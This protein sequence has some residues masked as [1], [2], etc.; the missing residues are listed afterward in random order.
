MGMLVDGVWQERGYDTSAGGRFQ[1]D[2]TRFHNWITPDGA[3]GPTGEGGFAAARGR[4]HLYVSLACPWA[5][6]SIIFRRLKKLEDVISLSIVDPVMR[7]VGWR[8]SDSPAAI[9]DFVNGKAWLSEIYLMTDP[10]FTGRVT[11]PVLWDKEKKTIVNNESS[12]II[13]MLNSAFDKFTNAHEDYYPQPLR[14]EIDRI[15][16]FVY[17][18]VNNGVYRAGFATTQAAYDEAFRH[19]FIALDEI[20]RHLATHRYLAG[21]RITE[22]DWRLFTTLVRFDAVYY[23]HFKC[24]LRRI[25][26]YANL[27]NYLRELYQWPGVKDTVSFDHIKTHYYASHRMINPTGIVPRGP[28]LDYGAPHDRARLAAVAPA[29]LATA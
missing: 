28:A 7:E 26:D 17:K 23:S 25:A 18:N 20:E 5:H 16:A 2:P 14:A 10:K 13:R 21:D 19:L 3:P 6:R 24:N 29:E 9:P 22:A 8:F 4:Y 11:V 12:E 1:R 27:S 15:N